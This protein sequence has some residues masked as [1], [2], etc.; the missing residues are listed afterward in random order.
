VSTLAVAD[1]PDSLN[2]LDKWV[3]RG[4]HVGA[5][6]HSHCSLNWTNAKTYIDDIDR[7]IELLSPWLTQARSRYF[8]YS[9]DMWGD[10][11]KKTDEVQAHLVRRGFTPAP[12]SSW[13][14]DVQ[15]LPSY[16]RTLV[17][18][19]A[20]GSA[21][22]HRA[23]VE[24]AVS[25]LRNQA[26]AARQVF[27]RDPI[28][29]GLV[30]GTPIAGDAWADVLTAYTDCGVEFVSLEEAMTDPANQIAAPLVTRFFRNSTQKWAEYAGVQ[31]ADTPPQTLKALESIRPIENMSESAALAP[32]LLLAAAETHAQLDPADL[33]WWPR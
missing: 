26:E 31:I 10:S 1:D 17:S 12:I 11:Q 24:T 2:A 21:L 16:L 9:F 28:H 25:A 30:H 33:D 32:A 23:F 15:F 18:N 22:V 6:T 19:D 14:Y 8:R 4:H 13:F 7:N 20:E 27:G 3:G 29:I 5:H